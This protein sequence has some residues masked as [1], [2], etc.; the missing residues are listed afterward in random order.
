MREV[1]AH[2]KASDLENA[3]Q[4]GTQLPFGETIARIRGAIDD[5]RARLG[6]LGPDP[7]PPR[8]GGTQSTATSRSS[9]RRESDEGWPPAGPDRPSARRSQGRLVVV[10]PTAIS[11]SHTARRA[12]SLASLP[13]NR[14][15]P[16]WTR[17]G[18]RRRLNR[19]SATPGIR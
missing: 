12:I 14:D 19:R 11:S 16:R 4:Q 18:H 13:R 5:E 9:T 10:R 17:S 3:R 7:R 1:A 15:H 6:S 8:P 2:I